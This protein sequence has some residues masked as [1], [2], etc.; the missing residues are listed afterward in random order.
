M[1]RAGMRERTSRVERAEKVSLT[2]WKI[3]WAAAP[4]DLTKAVRAAHQ[5]ITFATATPLQHAAACAL[6]AGSDYYEGLLAGYRKRRDYLVGE[7]ARIG[8]SVRPPAGTYYTCA[9]LSRFGY[10]RDDVAFCK[11][12][13]EDVGVAAIPPSASTS[14]EKRRG[15]CGSRLQGDADRRRRWSGWRNCAVASEARPRRD[16][17]PRNTGDAARLLA[18]A[19]EGGATLAVLPGCSHRIL[20][21][22]RGSRA[23]RRRV[24][25]VLR[26]QEREIG[27]WILAIVPDGKPRR[28]KGD[29]VSPGG[30]VVKS[31]IHPYLRGRTSLHG[32]D[33]VGRRRS[34]V[35][36]DARLLRRFSRAVPQARRGKDCSRGRE[37][38]RERLENWRTLLRARDR[39]SAY[40][41]GV[42]RGGRATVSPSPGAPRGRAARRDVVEADGGEQVL[43]A[44]VD[45]EVVKKLRARFPALSDRRPSAYRR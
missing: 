11:H 13:S 43:F 25:D 2:G 44:D 32:G 37:W 34:G 1:A 8:F 40:V 18:Q 27:L 5:F 17:S 19:K 6:S 30:A 36:D 41:V 28:G 31:R 4:P 42:N 10:E 15:M 33:R 26:D 45:P 24:G 9:D 22:A 7:L 12:L 20:E 21:D 16:T 14:S 38:T 3:G 23:G 39:E 29:V 35:R